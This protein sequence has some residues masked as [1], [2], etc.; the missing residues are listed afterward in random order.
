MTTTPPAPTLLPAAAAVL[1]GGADAVSPAPVM[2]AAA[3]ADEQ[4]AGEETEMA[5]VFSGEGAAP[6]LPPPRAASAL[7]KEHRVY[8]AMGNALR[9]RIFYLLART[10]GGL[11]IEQVA[12]RVRR[13]RSITGKHLAILRAAGLVAESSAGRDKLHRIAPGLASQP[14]APQFYDTG[15]MVIRIP[16]LRRQGSRWKE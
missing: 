9:R 10:P 2:T 16:A 11:S 5:P 8:D 7:W 13:K 12:G 1:P 4:G 14:G 3:G 15:W 6:A